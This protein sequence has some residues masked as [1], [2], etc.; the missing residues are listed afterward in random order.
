MKP[1]EPQLPEPELHKPEKFEEAAGT[2]STERPDYPEPPS[3]VPEPYPVPAV[4]RCTCAEIQAQDP[5]RHFK[6][7]ARR[8]KLPITDHVFVPRNVTGGEGPD[9]CGHLT[10]CDEENALHATVPSSSRQV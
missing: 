5:K 2:P 10:A 3:G 6:G 1:Y 9:R 7:C 8:E 4:E